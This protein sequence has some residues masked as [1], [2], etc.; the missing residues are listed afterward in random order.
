MPQLNAAANKNE[1][2]RVVNV[3]SCVHEIGTINL[4][5]FE[6]KN[7]YRAGMVYTD[8]KL[9]QVM[10]TKHLQKICDENSWRIQTHAAHPGM[11]NTDI[12]SASI[13]GPLS[14]YPIC[15]HWFKVNFN[16]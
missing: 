14:N 9:A 13:L 8:S 15:R 3:T 4:D 1:N 10:F 5:D 7:Y 12:F 2:A 11:V 16:F 6:Y